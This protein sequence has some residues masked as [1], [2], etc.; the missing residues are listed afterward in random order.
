V[1]ASRREQAKTDERL[2]VPDL[3]A[4]MLGGLAHA[5]LFS[6]VFAAAVSAVPPSRAG[7]AVT[8]VSAGNA[9]G[10]AVGVPLGTAVGSAVGL[11]VTFAAAAAL[12]AVLAVLIL[13]VLPRAAPPP[14]RTRCCPRSAG[15][16]CSPSR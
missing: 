16:R 5:G 15:D 1:S 8:F 9:V 3:A 6:V 11:R 4:R 14:W 2:V 10:L 12:M 7:R 13:V